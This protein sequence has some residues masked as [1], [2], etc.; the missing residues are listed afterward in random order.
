MVMYLTYLA[1]AVD[2]DRFNARLDL[3]FLRVVVLLVRV[4]LQRDSVDE[5][6]PPLIIQHHARKHGRETQGLGRENGT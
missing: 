5:L 6:A 1:V 2:V 4:F 3:P